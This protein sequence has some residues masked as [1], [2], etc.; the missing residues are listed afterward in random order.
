VLPEADRRNPSPNLLPDGFPWF[1]WRCGTRCCEHER[2]KL[3]LRLLAIAQN[4]C[5]GCVSRGPAI[6]LKDLSRA[7][8]LQRQKK[9]SFV[10]MNPIQETYENV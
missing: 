4:G 9:R 3:I 6:F 10:R 1:D 8:K 5:S 2:S 7:T